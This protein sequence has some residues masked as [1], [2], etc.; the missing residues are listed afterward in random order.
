MRGHGIETSMAGPREPVLS[1]DLARKMLQ[2]LPCCSEEH[3][4]G[5]PWEIKPTA[6]D[7]A[8]T[9]NVFAFTLMQQLQL[10]LAIYYLLLSQSQ[11]IIRFKLN[12]H[13]L[14]NLRI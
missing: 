14:I 4:L 6:S 12:K 13:S 8:M 11:N 3:A 10:S 1:I 7:Q 2:P 5:R 9:S